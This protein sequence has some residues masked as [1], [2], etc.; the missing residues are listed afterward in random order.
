[1]NM[2]AEDIVGIRHQ[3]TIGEDKADWED[4]VRAAVNCRMR[5]L[6]IAL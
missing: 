2:E 4:L 5:E 1:M 3:A 6:A